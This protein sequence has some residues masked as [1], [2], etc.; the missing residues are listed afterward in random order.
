M[1]SVLITYKLM[2]EG[3][4]TDL[5]KISKEIKEKAP[6][7]VEVAGVDKQP[8]AFGLNALIIN[9]VMGENRDSED[10]EKIIKEIPGV[11]QV[12]VAGMTRL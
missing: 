2:P 10:F 1:G 5:E 4:D 12:D 7:G 8:I 11:S 9:V 3:V 6:E